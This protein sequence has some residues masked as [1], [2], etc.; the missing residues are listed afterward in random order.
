[1]NSR[2]TI[3]EL[4]IRDNERQLTAVNPRGQSV[5]APDS[6][7]EILARLIEV[8]APGDGDLVAFLECYFDESGSHAGSPVLC[9]AGYLFERESCKALDLAW[10]QVLA[11]Y[12]LPF[13]HMTACAHNQRPFDQLSRDECIESEKKMIELINNHA[14]LGVAMAINESEYLSMLGKDSVA[15]SPYAFCCWQILAGIRAWIN[16]TNFQGEIAYF[17]ESGHDS[18]GEANAL[19]KRIFTDRGLR[20]GYRYVAHAF[21]DKQKVRPIQT[22]DILAWHWA[23]Q[24]KRLLNKNAQIRADCRALMS[25]PQ[26]E[27]FIGNRKTLGGLVAYQRTLKGLPVNNGVSGRF[28]QRWFWSSFEDENGLVI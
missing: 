13:F 2:C 20:D 26:H 22:A 4:E 5:I 14:L 1:V 6:N 15:G 24:M 12:K 23:T 3:P 28:G 8:L 11:Q 10:A 25:K 16:R 21:V 18:E 9:V 27:V 19:M 7:H 17:F